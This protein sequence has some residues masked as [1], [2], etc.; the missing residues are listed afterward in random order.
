M[1][2]PPSLDQSAAVR[3]ARRASGQVT[4]LAARI[5]AGQPFLQ[6]AQQLLAARGSLDSLLVRLVE[7]ELY[8]CVPRADARND[9]GWLLRTALGHRTGGHAQGGSHNLA[10][11][12]LS[13]AREERISP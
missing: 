11:E 2:P 5:A 1:T 10:G 4:A 12:S 6:V 8:E 13:A 3:H 9:V 7:L